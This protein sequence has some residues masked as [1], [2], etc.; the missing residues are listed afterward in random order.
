MKYIIALLCGCMLAASGFAESGKLTLDLALEMARINSPELRAARLNTQAAEKNVAASGRWKNPQLNVEAEGIGGDL[1]GVDDTEYTLALEQ[2]FER[3]GKRKSSRAVAERSIGIAFQTEAEKE[4]DLLAEVRLA[5]IE[6]FALQEI[7]AVR[8]EQEQLGRAF[9]DVAKRKHAAGGGSELEVVQAELAL[10]EI[11]LAQTC[12][13]GDLKA[14]RVRLASLIGTPEA[15][16]AELQGDY[17]TLEVLEESVIAESHPALQRMKA[18]IAVKQAQ[19]DLAKAK[20]AADI[21]LGAG[22]RY[23]AGSN[24]G[25]LVLGASMPLN[26]V[27]AGKAEQA[28]VLMQ[29]DGLQAQQNEV[30]RKLQQELSMLTAVYGGAK[31]EAE[32]TRDRLT[33]KAEKAYEL[34]RVGY[35]AGRFSW[36]ELINAQQHLAEIRIRYIEALKDAHLAR[37]EVSKFLEQGI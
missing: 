17:Y 23:E 1:N 33:P 35:D 32:M 16:M 14:A 4:L 20:D 9:V 31:L 26:F 25:S 18:E 19:A 6:V 13:L 7:G 37:A 29:V 28:S 34:S 24:E 11:L 3:G 21:T 12:C 27:R 2:T 5:F 10:E 30:R 36:F 15:Q 22:F 8:A